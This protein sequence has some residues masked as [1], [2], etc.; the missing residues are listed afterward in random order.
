MNMRRNSCTKASA[1][2]PHDKQNAHSHPRNVRPV[3]SR[4]SHPM[5]SRYCRGPL[6]PGRGG[7]HFRLRLQWDG[8]LFALCQP[9]RGRPTSLL[10]LTAHHPSLTLRLLCCSL[11]WRLARPCVPLRSTSGAAWR[12]RHI[13]GSFPDPRYTSSPRV[14]VVSSAFPADAG[15]TPPSPRDVE[16]VLSRAARKDQSSAQRGGG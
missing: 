15:A 13:T 3:H 10:S 2:T 5:C 8:S 4:N 12:L 16:R 11:A 14:R 1:A 7:S 9:L 6:T